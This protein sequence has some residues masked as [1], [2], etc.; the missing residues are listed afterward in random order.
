MASKNKDF[1]TLFK[2]E[3]TLQQHIEAHNSDPGAY[4]AELLNLIKAGV[5]LSS[6][7]KARAAALLW[8]AGDRATVKYMLQDYATM[9]IVEVLTMVKILDNRRKASRIERTIAKN[10]RMRLTKR[11]ELTKEMTTLKADALPAGGSG[12]T[13]ALMKHVR[14]WITSIDKAALEFFLLARPKEP[15]QE[16]TDLCHAN[17]N[18]FQLNY[19]LP[20]VYGVAP[21]EGSIHACVEG[22]ESADQIPALLEKNAALANCYSWI[23]ARFAPSTYSRR[24]KEALAAKIPLEEALTFYEELAGG[25]VDGILE[26]RIR[27]GEALSVEGD[28]RRQHNFGKLMERLLLLLRRKASFAPL[29][30]PRAEQMLREAMPACRGKGKKV[31][32]LGD[33]SASMQV[34]IDAAAITACAVCSAFD[35]DLAFFNTRSFKPPSLPRN[36]E[37]VCRIASKVRATGATA[38][39]AAL[40]SYFERREEVDLFVVVSDEDENTPC[41]TAGGACV[42][43]DALFEQYVAEVYPHA[44]LFFVSFLPQ[45]EPGKM[46]PALQARP[47]LGERARQFKFDPKRPDLSKLATLL[48]LIAVELA[49]D[50]ASDSDSD[51]PDHT[52]LPQADPEPAA[53]AAHKTSAE[54]VEETA[55][56]D[57]GEKMEG[58]AL[59]RAEREGSDSSVEDFGFLISLTCLDGTLEVE[60]VVADRLRKAFP[61]GTD[62]L[63]VSTV[64]QIIDMS[65]RRS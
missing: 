25:D 55:M 27:S 33:A 40:L 26:G 56:K 22:C 10:R 57:V 7:T 1:V 54:N 47:G 59:E 21:P 6:V 42:M 8:R 4:A 18:D 65:A 16:L 14:K 50:F 64:R 30:L 60:E 48:G 37:H 38:P 29:L 19:F 52:L 3:S 58:M 44:K 49:D 51:S 36:A 46:L 43:F 35:A 23:R 62:A 13:G 63:P 11:L 53:A 31:A 32:V 61:A 5:Y 39:A 45:I 34:A 41:K 9:G 28:G 15:W 12:A 17:P 24:T 20:S 2:A